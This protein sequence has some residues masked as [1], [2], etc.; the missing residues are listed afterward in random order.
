[1][2]QKKGFLFQS[3]TDSEVIAHLLSFELRTNNPKQAIKRLLGYLEGAFAIAI[4]FKNINLLAGA[5]RGSPLAL[6]VSKESTY[7][8]SD[9][10]ALAPFTQKIIFMEEGDSVLIDKK[11]RVT[12]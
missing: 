1:M 6:G 10:L 11:N 9:S 4:I 5:R 3:Q 2:L 12:R 7:L 8:G